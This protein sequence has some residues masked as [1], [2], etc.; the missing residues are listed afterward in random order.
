MSTLGPPTPPAPLSLYNV[1]AT[2]TTP[3]FGTV[4]AQGAPVRG[5][6]STD[7]NVP[8]RLDTMSPSESYRMGHPVDETVYRFVC[9][10]VDA[11]GSAITIKKDFYV[12]I[13]SVKYKVIGSGKRE[14]QSGQQTLVLKQEDQ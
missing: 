1:Y 6:G 14:G 12:T 9:P 2:I 5:V 3:E 8:G 10:V 7:S 13:D 4:D 11:G